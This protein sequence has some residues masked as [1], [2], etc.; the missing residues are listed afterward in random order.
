M[1]R[2]CLSHEGKLLKKPID[3]FFA[4]RLVIFKSFYQEIVLSLLSEIYNFTSIWI[5]IYFYPSMY[6]SIPLLES[7][8]P[9]SANH[10]EN[11]KKE[12]KGKWISK[13]G[14]KQVF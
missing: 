14:Y 9:S 3:I 10:D 12:E 4:K 8:S 2:V 13:T 1:N 6:L 7:Y 11:P 5:N